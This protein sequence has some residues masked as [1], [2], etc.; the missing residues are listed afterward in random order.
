METV[1]KE[2]VGF[3]HAESQSS[4]H[5]SC[6][7]GKV[8]TRRAERS[9]SVKSMDAI[10]AFGSGMIPD[11]QN[12]SQESVRWWRVNSQGCLEAS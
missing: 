5:I 8:I 11:P 9:P 1:R 7:E 4:G 12:G 3:I 6:S 2:I 10:L